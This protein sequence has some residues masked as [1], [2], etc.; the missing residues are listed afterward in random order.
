MVNKNLAKGCF[1]LSRVILRAYARHQKHMAQS[2]MLL[3]TLYIA[4]ILFTRVKRTYK[5]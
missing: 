4:S 5:T 1:P 2:Y 3:A